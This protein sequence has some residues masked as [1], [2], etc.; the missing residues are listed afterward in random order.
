MD[1]QNALNTA[2]AEL[3]PQ[4]WDYTDATGTTLTVI[5]AGLR[6]DPGCAEVIVRIRAL[7]H[8]VDIE[9]GVPSRDLPSMIDALTGNRLWS[10]DTLDDITVILTPFGGGGM[11]LALSEDLDATEESQ[12]HVPEEQRLPLAS[13]LS[14]ALDVARAWEG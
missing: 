6:E 3:T 12:V 9:A 4:P 11:L 1:F 7:A 2:I 14:R 13:A 10:Y 5:P 8:S